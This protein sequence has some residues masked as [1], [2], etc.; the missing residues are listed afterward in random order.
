M[1]RIVNVRNFVENF[2]PFRWNLA[3]YGHVHF[4]LNII[5][6]W[7]ELDDKGLKIRVM[8]VIK[9]CCDLEHPCVLLE[10]CNRDGSFR[11]VFDHAKSNDAVLGGALIFHSIYR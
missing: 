6:F 2:L 4:E 8:L 11:F 3:L 1:K 10:D 9:K 7:V 5:F